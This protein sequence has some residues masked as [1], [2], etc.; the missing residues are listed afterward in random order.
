MIA[1]QEY[2]VVSHGERYRAYEMPK[3]PL[4]PRTESRY[5]P[6]AES[7][8]R[9][10]RAARADNS[11]A[12]LALVRQLWCCLGHER[13]GIQVH[14]L[15]NGPARKTRG[16][17]MKST[18]RW[19]VPIL[20]TRPEELE[21]LGSRH[22]FRFFLQDGINPYALASALWINTGDL[23]RM[24]RVLELREGRLVSR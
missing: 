7:R 24:G 16:L 23:P 21:R 4:V 9:A 18:D 22:E 10:K 3:R 20:W 15:R 14:H 17:G 8:A 11:L 13:E 12:H 5:F 2:R 6:S 1:T 19:V